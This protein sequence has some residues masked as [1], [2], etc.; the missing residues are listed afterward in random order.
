LIPVVWWYL[1]GL[2]RIVTCFGEMT[3]ARVLLTVVMLPGLDGS[4]DF[5][6]KGTR[7]FEAFGQIE[8]VR[9]PRNGSQS[10][11]ALARFVELHLPVG[12][13]FI[14]VAESFSGPIGI[15]LASS[16]IARMCAL[17]LI[18]TFVKAP[19]GQT[20]KWIAKL[21]DLAKFIIPPKAIIKYLLLGEDISNL[22]APLRQFLNHHDRA[23]LLE[24]AKAALLCDESI[25]LTKTRVPIL[26]LVANQDRLLLGSLSMWGEFSNVEAVAI[27]GPHFL[28][29]EGNPQQ[30]E[31][32]LTTFL[33]K[34]L[35]KET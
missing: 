18:A 7:Y 19:L 11:E 30:I 5:F 17:V 33:N 29:Q 3:E 21:V 24:R 20:S 35:P 1:L 14:V 22:A 32:A 13:P 15:K 10:Y 23:A 26:A 6:G 12:A 4:G 16:N 25:A 31:L 9:Y 27:D 2:A 34:A 28:L 8:I